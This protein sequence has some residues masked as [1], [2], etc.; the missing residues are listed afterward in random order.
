[1]YYHYIQL[2]QFIGTLLFSPIQRPEG[3]TLSAHGDDAE[4]I[5]NSIYAKPKVSVILI[6]VV[7]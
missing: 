5:V 4:T 1:M 2:T 7:T 6:C 3:G